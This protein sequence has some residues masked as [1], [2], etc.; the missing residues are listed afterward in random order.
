MGLW[1]GVGLAILVFGFG[2]APGA[3]PGFAIVRQDRPIS[4][5]AN[6]AE[7]RFTDVAA[8]IDPTTVSF[9]SL[10]DTSGT[11]VTEQNFQF[12]LVNP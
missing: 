1:G 10:T 7:V 5:G 3:I 8:L 12:D 11:R 4:L 2:A 6:I 9:V